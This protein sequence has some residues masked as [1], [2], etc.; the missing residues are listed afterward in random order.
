MTRKAEGDGSDCL[1]LAAILSGLMAA[2]CLLLPATPPTGVGGL[3]IVEAFAMLKDPNFLAFIAISLVVAGTMQFYFLGSAC[4]LTDAGLPNSKIPATMA[5]AQA[6]QAIATFFAMGYLLDHFG[7]K[8]TL[9]VGAACWLTM[10]TAYVIT[11]PRWLLVVSQSLHGLAYVF[12]IIVGQIYASTVGPKIPGSMQALIFAA[13]TGVG[14]FLGTQLAGA[15][16]DFASAGGKFQWRKVW[17][18]PLVIVLGGVIALILAFN[19]PG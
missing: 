1:V 8:W 6:A 3:P 2:A 13:T 11:R 15:T 5:I 14:L 10:Y 4:F 18:V 17:S 16:M 12:F 19:P 7:F 9:T